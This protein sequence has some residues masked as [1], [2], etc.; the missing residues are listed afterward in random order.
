MFV[1]KQA[2]LNY[3]YVYWLDFLTF[4]VHFLHDE[5]FAAAATFS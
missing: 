1:Y 2:Q 5:P 4:D 3:D